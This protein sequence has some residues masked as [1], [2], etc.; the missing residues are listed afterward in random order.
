VQGNIVAKSNK[1]IKGDTPGIKWVKNFLPGTQIKFVLG[2]A[3]IAVLLSYDAQRGSF[4]AL[5]FS[6]M[7]WGGTAGLGVGLSVD[8]AKGTLKLLSEARSGRVK[9]T[10]PFPQPVPRNQQRT[11]RVHDGRRLPINTGEGFEYALPKG[12]GTI[13]MRRRRDLFWALLGRLPAPVLPPPPP[14]GQIAKSRVV[15]MRKFESADH[16]GQ[17]VQILDDDLRAFLK[18]AWRHNAR[19]SGLSLNRWTGKRYRLPLWYKGKGIGWY[20]AA[21][22]LIADAEDA[23]ETQL[24]RVVRVSV[25]IAYLVML[26]DE[27]QTYEVLVAAEGSKN[28]WGDK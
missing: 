11:I 15:E 27:Y 9:Q 23:T 20:W 3:V 12:G 21:L 22:N 28:N 17:Q 14:S 1:V 6:D 2:G 16:T 7:I 24:V 25:K 5:R 13:T 18:I 10:R 26:L 8:A 4:A 19:G